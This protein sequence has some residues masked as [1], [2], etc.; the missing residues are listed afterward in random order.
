MLQSCSAVSSP[1][2]RSMWTLRSKRVERDLPHHRVDHVLDLGGEHGLALLLVGGLG[3]QLLE[4]QH[5]AEHARGLGQR[6]RR[7]RHQRAVRRRQHLMHAVAE[8]VG[9]RHHVARLAL[10]VEHHIGMRRRHGRMR[11]GAGRFSG[12]RRR[13]DPA[14][15]EEALGDRRHLRRERA[16]G[17]EHGLLRLRPGDG[18]HR[19]LRQRRVAVPVRQLLLAEPARLQRVIAVRQPRIGLAHRRHQRVHH[20]GLDAVGEMA[21]LRDVGEAA[22]A[23][24]NL[25]VLG[26]R[27][28][29]QREEPQVLLEGLGQRLG[30]GL[31]LL[32]VGVLH[33]C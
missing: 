5:L 22:P 33:A 7:R 31:A 10:V 32:R 30:R 13:I 25:L 8:L 9:E 1:L 16:V 24:G 14:V 23:V 15:V 28:G 17:G 11:E 20:L 2:R 26:E 18:A 4:G 27:V 21:R 3:Q 6:Q 12:P 19:D 29:D